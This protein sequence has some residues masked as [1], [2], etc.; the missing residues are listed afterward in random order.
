MA[1][2]LWLILAVPHRYELLCLSHRPGQLTSP[3]WHDTA[4]RT[5]LVQTGPK[6]LGAVWVLSG[7]GDLG[8]FQMAA[9]RSICRS[10]VLQSQE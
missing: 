1:I 7:N 6:L 2:A 8:C 9:L 10:G 3:E 4:S 5:A